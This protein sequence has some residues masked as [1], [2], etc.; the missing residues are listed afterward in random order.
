MLLNPFDEPF[1]GNDVWRLRRLPHS[2]KRFLVARLHCITLKV[3]VK[4]FWGGFHRVTSMG[5]VHLKHWSGFYFFSKDSR[6]RHSKS[7]GNG[8]TFNCKFIE[9][10]GGW[11]HQLAA[12][13]LIVGNHTNRL[14]LRRQS[15]QSYLYIINLKL[16]REYTYCQRVVYW[17]NV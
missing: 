10:A 4:V 3:T 9:W 6:L 5:G 7:R 16:M 12:E 1:Y 17:P 14:I 15:L 11:F 2:Q 8:E 13:L